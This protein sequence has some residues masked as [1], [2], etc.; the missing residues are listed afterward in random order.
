MLPDII[1]EQIAKEVGLTNPT[2]ADETT[3]LPCRD[4]VHHLTCLSGAVGEGVAILFCLA[5]APG[6]VQGDLPREVPMGLEWVAAMYPDQHTSVGGDVGSAASLFPEPP[7]TADCRRPYSCSTGQQ[8]VT[9]TWCQCGLRPQARR[10]CWV[11]GCLLQESLLPRLCRESFNGDEVLD[12][13]YYNTVC[14]VAQVVPSR[15]S[16]TRRGLVR[17]EQT[18]HHSTCA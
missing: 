9:D 4:P 13:Q 7:S 18:A 2:R 1:A 15:F 17:S 12:M 3:G 10:Q 8:A 5:F 14:R 6:P 16:L 11:E